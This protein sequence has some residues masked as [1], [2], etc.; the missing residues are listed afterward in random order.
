MKLQLNNFFLLLIFCSYPFFGQKKLPDLE[1]TDS[2][3]QYPESAEKVKLKDNEILVSF[4]ST[5]GLSYELHID[6]FVFKKDGKIKYT[7]EEVFFKRGK[8]HKVKIL[9]LS[10]EKQSKIFE[11]IN[12]EFFLNFSKLTQNDFQH[13]RNNHQIC[14]DNYVHD[15][16][17]NFVIIKQNNNTSEL[18]VYLLKENE[19]CTEE[20]SPLRK[21]INLH[22]FFGIGLSR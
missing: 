15:A 4:F 17:E 16:T 1:L 3:I 11:I 7:K 18:F 12:S 8:K 22:E 9:D 19:N 20:N 2:K 5:G 6:N 14:R 10:Y 13:S 21:F